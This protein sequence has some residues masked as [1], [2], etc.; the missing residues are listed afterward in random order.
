VEEKGSVSGDLLGERGD[1]A[2]AHR[3]VEGGEGE[4]RGVVSDVAGGAE[5]EDPFEETDHTPGPEDEDFDAIECDP[6]AED[7]L[8]PGR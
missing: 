3:E 2:D 5:A 7:E 1:Q 6:D 8:S 4:P